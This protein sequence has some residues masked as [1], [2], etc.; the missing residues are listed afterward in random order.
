MT[1]HL[2][3]L[4]LDSDSVMIF[5]E[6][7]LKSSSASDHDNASASD[8]GRATESRAGGP[9]AHGPAP[10]L[11]DDSDGLPDLLLAFGRPATWP[12]RRL[13]RKVFQ[14][15]CCCAHPAPEATRNP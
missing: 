1:V 10:G 4:Q 9:P 3:A 15:C 14:I 2:R 11:F 13:G 7:G 8:G 12:A 6:A 5:L